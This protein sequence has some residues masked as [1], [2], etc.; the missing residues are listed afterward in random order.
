MPH[1]FS[2]LAVKRFPL[3]PFANDIARRTVRS[4]GSNARS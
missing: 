3:A 4:N 1:V 2:M